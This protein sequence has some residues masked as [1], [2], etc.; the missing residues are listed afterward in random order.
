[1]NTCAPA[2]LSDARS[3]GLSYEKKNGRAVRR[4]LC[5]WRVHEVKRRAR[6]LLRKSIQAKEQN[7]AAGKAADA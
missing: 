7:R 2:R 1:M 6:L 4:N 5:R 3:C